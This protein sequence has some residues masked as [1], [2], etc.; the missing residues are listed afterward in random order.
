[1]LMPVVQLLALAA[2]I[3]S[4]V[5][6]PQD[7]VKDLQQQAIAALKKVKVNGTEGCSVKNAAVR[8][9]WYVYLGAMFFS[10]LIQ[11]LGTQCRA[12]SAKHTQLLY[13]ACLL[14]LQSQTQP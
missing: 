6:K 10:L 12:R 7:A 5:A 1:M 4:A 13:N 14:P 9:D 11:Y 3:Q 2:T 8:K